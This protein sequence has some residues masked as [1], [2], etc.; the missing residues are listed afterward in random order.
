MNHNVIAATIGIEVLIQHCHTASYNAGWWHDTETGLPHLP[1]DNTVAGNPGMKIHP[2]MKRMLVNLFPQIVACKLALTHSEI[3]EAMEG[4]RRGIMD[5]KL[6]H[7]PAIEVELADVLIR[8]FDLA[9]ALGLD[10]AGA[11]REKIVYNTER[12]DHKIAERR[13]LGG[14]LF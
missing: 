11:V 14:K 13:K 3:S 5:D 9:G 10:I 1:N 8:V 7:R 6:Q 12:P 4:F 2:Q